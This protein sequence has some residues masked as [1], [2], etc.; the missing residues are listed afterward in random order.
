MNLNEI[1]QPTPDGYHSEKDDNSVYKLDE[2]RKRR[3]KLTL[4]KL[5]RLRIMNDTRKVEH[6]EK[7]DNISM[8]YK[9]PSAEAPAGG[10]GI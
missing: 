10:L 1:Y 8:Q 3:T 6:E 4:E 7:L 2:P 9:P 5:N